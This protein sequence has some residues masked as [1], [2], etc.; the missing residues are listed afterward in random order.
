LPNGNA[1]ADFSQQMLFEVA[2]EVANKVGGIYTV[3]RTKVPTTV[4]EFGERYCLIGPWNKAKAAMEVDPMEIPSKPFREAVENMRAAG[5]DVMYGKWLIDGAPS[6]L[7]FD[8]NSARKWLSEWKTDIWLS[9]QI[10]SPPDDSETDEAILFGY[11][12]QWFIGEVFKF[13]R[14][15]LTT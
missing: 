6:V 11:L 4:A 9:S 10:P 2:W 3:I 14:I 8:L 1:P 15:K 5:V 13:K 12:V 7:L